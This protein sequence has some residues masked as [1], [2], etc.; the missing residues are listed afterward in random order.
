MFR[1][2]SLHPGPDVSAAAA[3]SL[4]GV[5]LMR[6]REAL[7][8]LTRAYLVTEHARGRFTFHDL[9]RIYAAR[10]GTGVDTETECH[11]AVRRMLDHYLHTGLAAIEWLYPD[12]AVIGLIAP[13]PPT[14]TAEELTSREQA[15]AWCEAEQKALPAIVTLAVSRG[16]DTHAWQIPWILTAYFN[17][18]GYL[19]E[20]TTTLHA[21]LAAARRAGDR[22]GQAL[23]I[24]ELGYAYLRLGIY[25]QARVHLRHAL[26]L[27]RELGD[28]AEQAHNHIELAEVEKCQGHV[29]AALSHASQ[30]SALYLATGHRTGRARARTREA[31][32][33]TLRGEYERALDCTLEAIALQRELGEKEDRYV[34]AETLKA[35]GETHQHLGN[36]PQ[37]IDYHRQAL[38]LNQRLGDHYTEAETLVRL[39]DAYDAAAET[40]AAQDA[41]RR[42]V[43]ILQDLHHPDAALIR[44]KLSNLPPR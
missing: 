40:D 5:P 12:R 24:H 18:Q 13:D 25:D 31:R 4:A 10:Q 29:D 6:A 17:R 11:A 19:H 8:E 35:L 34:T 32:C 16:F 20:W 23:A 3:A 27:N 37:A 1:M 26:D 36:Y 14:S 28:R 7:A 21:A 43:A 41:W 44:A 15:W 30:S 9:L 38:E 22:H 2:I 33:L 42:A 39:G